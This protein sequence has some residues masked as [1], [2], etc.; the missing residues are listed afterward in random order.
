MVGCSAARTYRNW[1]NLQAFYDER[2]GECSGE[3][4]FGVHNWANA[5][6]DR[7]SSFDKWR[8]SVVA[9]TGDVYAFDYNG[10]EVLLLG[11]VVPMDADSATAERINAR[12]SHDSSNYPAMYCAADR[13]LEGW[14]GRESLGRPLHWSRS[15]SPGSRERRDG[16]C[17]ASAAA[18]GRP[19][20]PGNT[21]SEQGTPEGSPVLPVRARAPPML[22]EWEAARRRTGSCA[23]A[24]RS[25][26]GG[27]CCC[28]SW[29]PKVQRCEV[30]PICE[31]RR[32]AY[33][34]RVAM[35]RLFSWRR[36]D[37]YFANRA[38]LWNYMVAVNQN[39]FEHHR[40]SLTEVSQIVTKAMRGA[41][42]QYGEW[43]FE[44]SQARKCRRSSVVRGIAVQ[45]RTAEVRAARMAGGRIEEVAHAVRL[46]CRHVSRIAPFRRPRTIC[47]AAHSLD[48]R[49]AKGMANVIFETLN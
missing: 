28:A 34:R 1:P 11:T 16:G 42:Q 39:R 23:R 13:L 24:T 36:K 19:T 37:G 4:D 21:R 30:H 32:N 44:E 43:G 35:S 47:G 3:S 12:W 46:S 49:G 17:V 6:R 48:P 15:G 2:G 5:A 27:R 10:K 45:Q 25:L 14:A 18:H 33:L 31:G 22:C 7:E 41:R 29:T 38:R 8:V 26:T 40:L 9:D 20:A